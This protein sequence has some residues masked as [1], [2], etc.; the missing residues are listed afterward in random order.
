MKPFEN[1]ISYN[2]KKTHAKINVAMEYGFYLE[3]IMLEYAILDNRINRIIELLKLDITSIKFSN[4]FKAIKKSIRSQLKDY[5]IDADQSHLITNFV[6]D[7]NKLTH[8]YINLDFD[9]VFT[10]KVALDGLKIVELIEN[11]SRK[12]KKQINFE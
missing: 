7:R 4:R 8:E 3:A 10:E 1:S 5:T 11:I 12:I 2:F 9:D 6:N